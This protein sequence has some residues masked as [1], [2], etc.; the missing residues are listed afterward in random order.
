MAIT[1]HT[2]VFKMSHSRPIRKPDSAFLGTDC[3]F[4]YVL[5]FSLEAAA[6]HNAN[7][8]STKDDGSSAGV[9][10]PIVVCFVVL[11]ACGGL[12]WFFYKRKRSSVSVTTH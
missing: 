6:K 9:V 1:Y 4:L 11:I 2:T 10:V 3:K 8:S 5:W 12:A 7:R